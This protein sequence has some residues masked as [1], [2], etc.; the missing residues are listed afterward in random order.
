MTKT[1]RVVRNCTFG[2]G[3]FHTDPDAWF[4]EMPG[5]LV[6]KTGD[7]IEV[8]DTGGE[9]VEIIHKPTG[10]HMAPRILFWA[11][12]GEHCLKTAT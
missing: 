12:I 7:V 5:A 11:A 10:S 3:W 9:N 4:N 2:P 8:K 1:L 6:L